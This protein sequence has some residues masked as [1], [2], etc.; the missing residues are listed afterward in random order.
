MNYQYNNK[1]ANVV[2][3]AIIGLAFLLLL[4][5]LAT[6]PGSIVDDSNGNGGSGSGGSNNNGD[7]VWSGGDIENR[8][9]FQFNET[10]KLGEEMRSQ[11]S[12]P[13]IK[14]GSAVE[15]KQLEFKSQIPLKSSAFNKNS[16]QYTIPKR[17]LEDESLQ[18]ILI[19]P[20]FESGRINDEIG[21]LINS[22]LYSSY[23]SHLDFPLKIDVEDLSRNQTQI[24]LRT[25]QVEWYQLSRSYEELLRSIEIVG[26]YQDTRY[27]EREIQFNVETDQE[28]LQSIGISLSVVCPEEEDGTN[29]IEVFV[30][31]FKVLSQ[32][33]Q[34]TSVVAGGTVLETQVPL[35]VLNAEDEFA[36][37]SSNTLRLE[38][39]GKYEVSLRVDE[40]SFND[41]YTYTF[42]LNE[43]SDL[44][45][46]IVFGDFNKEQLD[47]QINSYRFSIPR[48]ETYSIRNRVRPGKNVITFHDVPVELREFTI[49]SFQE[50]E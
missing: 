34:C 48:K 33:P 30:N 8:V 39:S 28:F 43:Y 7:D 16:Y 15:Y 10:T 25:P 37:F 47:V 35:E 23:S 40:I 19:I 29:P 17:Y 6:E 49:E 22:Q 2:G 50:R 20:S 45:D 3:F 44:R 5:S 31:D 21:L 1:S 38:T 9:L 11:T 46:I 36:G 12:F 27:S 4:G 14:I 13:N 26:I 18:A 41:K 32:N 24:E 42:D